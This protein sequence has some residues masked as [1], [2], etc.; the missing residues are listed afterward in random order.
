[1]YCPQNAIIEKDFPIGVIQTGVINPD[2]VYSM[3]LLNI[4]EMSGV[5]LIRKL[6]AVEVS[7]DY[8]YIFDSSPGV[9]CPVMETIKNT[10]FALVVTEPSPMGLHDLILAVKL[11]NL[12]NLPFG[13]VINRY[14]G[15]YPEMEDFINETKAVF[16]Y[17][18]PFDRLA[19]E[20][21]ASGALTAEIS[22]R[23]EKLFSGLWNE[24]KEVLR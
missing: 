10:D 19:A 17:K 5:R 18:M 24:I 22:P 3:G 8:L 23:W 12:K 4:G 16:L 6:K 20:I 1:M 13:I 15:P 2:L 21:Y 9:S 7:H 11:L 14:E